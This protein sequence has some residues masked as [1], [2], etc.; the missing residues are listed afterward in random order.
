[1]GANYSPTLSQQAHPSRPDDAHASL[2]FSARSA[3]DANGGVHP[4][5]PARLRRWILLPF[6][7]PLPHAHISLSLSSVGEATGGGRSGQRRGRRRARAHGDGSDE[8]ARGGAPIEVAVHHCAA[9]CSL[10]SFL[11]LRSSL[12]GLANNRT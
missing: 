10:A 6:F 7:L 12:P 8:V 5:A 1:L 9:I 2:S 3:E 4:P 11:C